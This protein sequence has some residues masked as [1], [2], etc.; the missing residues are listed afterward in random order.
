M[1]LPP[2]NPKIDVPRDAVSQEVEFMLLDQ[3]VKWIAI[4]FDR[5]DGS[6]DLFKVTPWIKDPTVS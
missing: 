2:P 1:A 4:E 5:N 6:D 3:R